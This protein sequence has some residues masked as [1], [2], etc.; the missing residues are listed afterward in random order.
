MF[1][2]WWWL[3]IS[4][5]LLCYI[6]FSF[7]GLVISSRLFGLVLV[8]KDF[9]LKR[10]VKAL[11]GWGSVVLALEMAHRY[12]LHEALSAEIMVTKIAGILSGQ[13]WGC[14]KK[15]WGL[16]GSIVAM[17]ARVLQILFSPQGS[18]CWGDPSWHWVQLAGLLELT[19]APMSDE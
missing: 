8:G 1:F 10:G 4:S 14:L 11:A 5:F 12:S 7:G 19:V 18:C 9:P 17:T 2:L 6:V 15:Q 3:S 13:P 16:L